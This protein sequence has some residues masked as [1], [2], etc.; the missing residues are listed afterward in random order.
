MAAGATYE[1]I[2]TTTAS[3]SVNSITF[4]SFSGYTDLV[5]IFLGK[6]SSGS[7]DLGLR[8]NS[9]TGSN[10]SYTLLTSQA[11]GTSLRGSDTTSITLT[12]YSYLDAVSNTL[13]VTNIFNYANTNVYK[14]ILTRGNKTGYGVET[15][16]GMWRSTSAITSMTVFTTNNPN[17]ESGSTFTLYGIAAA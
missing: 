11:G 1:P 2:A 14:S 9:D 10:Y 7:G 17:F 12:E 16:V 3:G 5:L 6:V 13:S 15:K 4:S 8:F